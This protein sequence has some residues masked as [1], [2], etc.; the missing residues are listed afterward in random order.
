MAY[1]PLYIFFENVVRSLEFALLG[2]ESDLLR[3]FFARLV[4]PQLNLK[5]NFSVFVHGA[6]AQWE[7]TR[8]K[9]VV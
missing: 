9:T 5:S 3:S 1:V 2:V 6:V 4:L 8:L 7:S